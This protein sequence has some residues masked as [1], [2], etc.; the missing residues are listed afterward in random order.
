MK[1]WRGFRLLLACC[2]LAT[3]TGCSTTPT[4]SE[5][6]VPPL[7]SELPAQQEPLL[8]GELPAQQAPSPESQLVALAHTLLNVPYRYGGNTPETGLDCSGFIGYVFR[9]SL[10]I[11][12]PRR[13]VEIS[14]IGQPIERAAL[15]PGD[16]VFFNTRGA[17]NSHAGIYIGNDQFIHSPSSGGRVHIVDMAGKYWKNRYNGARRLTV[18]AAPEVVAR[19]RIAF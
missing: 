19:D 12:L 17:R 11:I 2:L 9:E 7:A 6:P 1:L 13:V 10:G 5:F 14:R 8:A 3:V 16:L 18:A 15:L 4:V